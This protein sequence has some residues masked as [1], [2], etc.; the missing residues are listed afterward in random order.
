MQVENYLFRYIEAIN[1]EKFREGVEILK[2]SLSFCDNESSFII[3]GFIDAAKTLNALKYGDFDIVE[4]LWLS[5]EESKSKILP[6]N[7]YY[8]IFLEMSFAVEDKKEYYERI[9]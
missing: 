5:Y 7:R 1:E 8:T 2:S 3:E 9:V 6:K 4:R